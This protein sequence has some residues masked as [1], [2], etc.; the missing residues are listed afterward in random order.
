MKK[1]ECARTYLFFLEKTKGV[2]KYF[3][4][5]S[6]FNLKLGMSDAEIGL[7]C[8]FAYTILYIKMFRIS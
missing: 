5:S 8:C 2:S 6:V 4:Y 1:L 3:I 7:F